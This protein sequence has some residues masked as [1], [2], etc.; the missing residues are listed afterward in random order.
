M[1]A[2]V[3]YAPES[4]DAASPAADTHNLIHFTAVTNSHRNETGPSHT[5]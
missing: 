1:S 3:Q 2:R 4:A 5:N